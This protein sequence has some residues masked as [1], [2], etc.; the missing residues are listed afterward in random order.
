MV[1]PLFLSKVLAFGQQRRHSGG[2]VFYGLRKSY[3]AGQCTNVTLIPKVKTLENMQ[4]LRPIS[5]C[6]VIYKLGSKVLANRLM[7]LLHDIISPNQSAFVLG[8]QISD[9]SL[10]AFEISHFLKRCYGGGQGY[11]ALKLDMSKAYD[12]VEW[13]FLEAVMDEGG[14]GFRNMWQFNQAL[15]AKQGWRILK[16]PNSLLARVLKAKYY[17]NSNFLKASVKPGDS[18]AWRSLMKGKQVLVNGSRYLVGSGTSIS[19]WTDP[20]LPRPYTFKPCLPVMEGLED[21]VVADLIDE[22]TRSW[23]LEWLEE[24][25]THEEVDMIQ[26]IPLSA[27]RGADVLIWHYDKR[28]QYSVNSG[29]KVA[30]IMESMGVQASSLS[31][32]TVTLGCGGGCGRLMY[33]L[34]SELL[35]GDYSNKFFQQKK[36]Y[37]GEGFRWVMVFVFSAWENL[38]LIFIYSRNVR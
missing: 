9:N 22:N 3:E 30:R 8:R 19:V 4:Q 33:N 12:K 21:L 14:L 5:L 32:H 1:L 37:Q 29:Y 13:P 23:S 26:R 25:F 34:K 6:N 24:L 27:R 31:G 17:P 11:G 16:E 36:R 35:H 38:R 2:E 28:G 20:W 10:L 7:G 15:L 18:Y